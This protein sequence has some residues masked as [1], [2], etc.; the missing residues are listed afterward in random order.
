MTNQRKRLSS[1]D[2]ILADI[3]TLE[4]RID[5]ADD[6]SLEKWET[7]LSNEERSVTQQSTNTGE[8]VSDQGDQ[9]DKSQDNWPTKAGDMSDEERI[10]IA[11]RLI[12]MAKSLTK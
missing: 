3:E 1:R 10:A 8:T 7:E 4:R 11:T 5:A 9:N 2:V 6:A 12:R